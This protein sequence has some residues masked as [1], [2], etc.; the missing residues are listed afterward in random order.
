MI[1]ALAS[2]IGHQVRYAIISGMKE[3]TKAGVTQAA[4]GEYGLKA[5]QLRGAEATGAEAAIDELLASERGKPGGPLLNRG[6]A[7]QTIAELMP[8]SGYDPKA[9]PSP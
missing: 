3:A 8:V 7:T 9:A 1:H 5:L 6:Q 2:E 4:I